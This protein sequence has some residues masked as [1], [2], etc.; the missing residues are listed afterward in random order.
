M[1]A[2]WALAIGQDGAIVASE[3]LAEDRKP[4]L[5]LRAFLE[6]SKALRR[7]LL[8]YMGRLFM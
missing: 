8:L 5:V 4:S 6:G 3:A 7:L 1:S 2:G